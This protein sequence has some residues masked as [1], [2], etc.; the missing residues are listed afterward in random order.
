MTLN[1]LNLTSPR[2]VLLYNKYFSEHEPNIPEIAR[3][4]TRLDFFSHVQRLFCRWLHICDLYTN[5]SCIS[6]S[7]GSCRRFSHQTFVCQGKGSPNS[8]TGLWAYSGNRHSQWIPEARKDGYFGVEIP[9]YRDF[10]SYKCTSLHQCITAKHKA[11]DKA[12]TTAI[13]G[14]TKTKLL[15]YDIRNWCVNY[16][17]NIHS[18]YTS[19]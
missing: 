4:L 19:P 18:L 5:I 16:S 11:E 9:N 3:C 17:H 7:L 13:A 12:T 15:L 1:V 8:S 10:P 2:Q 14:A 6:R